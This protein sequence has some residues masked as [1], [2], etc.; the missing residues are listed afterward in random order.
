MRV[1]GVATS[2]PA[3]KLKDTEFVIRDF[4]EINFET[5][6]DYLMVTD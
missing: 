2:H 5:V 4:T 3:D 1:I 6:R